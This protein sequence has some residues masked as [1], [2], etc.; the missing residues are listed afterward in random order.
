MARREMTS[1]EVDARAV[2]EWVGKERPKRDSAWDR[3]KALEETR[4][5]MKIG[6]WKGA[7]PKHFVELFALRHE[8]VYGVEALELRP[9]TERT[10]AAFLVAKTLREHFDGDP[11]ELAWFIRW[12]WQRA[13]RDEKKRKAGVTNN[14]FRISWRWQ[15][16]A[17]LVTDYRRHLLHEGA[18]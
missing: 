10:R 12:V 11:N 15:F 9:K 1:S 6:D 17:R 8:Q 13:E 16:A 18:R 14:D 4:M 7:T 5:M 2:D 3:K